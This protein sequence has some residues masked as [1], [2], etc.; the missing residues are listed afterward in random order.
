MRSG[1]LGRARTAGG[2]AVIV[3][4]SAAD[5]PTATENPSMLESLS[6]NFGGFVIHRQTSAES[7][8]WVAK[9]FGTREM[10]QSTD[11]T[12]GGGRFAEGTGSRRRAREFVVRPDELKELGVGQAYVWAP[13][14]PAAGTGGCRDPTAPGRAPRARQ[15][16]RLRGRR[17]ADA[18]G[19]Q[20]AAL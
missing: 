7:R 18:R 10:W 11:R 14:G 16:G 8:E 17:P 6:D 2:Q 12:S 20:R 13:S 4:Q 1:I 19:V 5:V 15:R 9:L 3:T